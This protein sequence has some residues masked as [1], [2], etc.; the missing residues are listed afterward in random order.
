MLE[1]WTMRKLWS[2]ERTAQLQALRAQGLNHHQIRAIMGLTS[3]AYFGKC[4]RLKNPHAD[5]KRYRSG[6][7]NPDWRYIETWAERKARR[8][9]E[10]ATA[11]SPTVGRGRTGDGA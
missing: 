10:A 3:G 2:P 6:D 1:R 5:G 11:P 4:Y 9:R 8:A 7:S